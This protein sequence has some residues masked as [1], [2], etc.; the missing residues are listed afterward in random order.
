LQINDFRFSEFFLDLVP[1]TY[2]LAV[3]G[4]EAKRKST[5]YNALSFTNAIGWSNLA[6]AFSGADSKK[7][8]Y[9]DILPIQ[10]TGVVK[11]KAG[12]LQ[13]SKQT[14][15][16]LTRLLKQERVPRWVIK[17]LAEV[18]MLEMIDQEKYDS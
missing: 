7:L 2:L 17:M 14:L 16:I 8:D 10:E 4:V 6:N 11:V 1:V 15:K 12:L 18:E 5:E 3:L 13:P 9:K